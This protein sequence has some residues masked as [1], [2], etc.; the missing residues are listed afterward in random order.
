MVDKK[1]KRMF[2]PSIKISKELLERLTTVAESKGYSSAE[3]YALHV[4]DE[5]VK[6]ADEALSE[7]EVKKRLKGLSYLE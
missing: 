6:E 7:E 2:G 4:L 5:A 1:E 3:E